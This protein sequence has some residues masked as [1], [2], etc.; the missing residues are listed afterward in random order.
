MKVYKDNTASHFQVNMRQPLELDNNWE[1]G[2]SELHFPCAWDNVRRG[3][4]K[5]LVRWRFQDKSMDKRLFL[6]PKVVPR[7]Y[8]ADTESL[9]AKVNELVKNTLLEFSKALYWNMIKFPDELS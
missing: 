3:S 8:Y 6:I 9:L 4:N 2:L 1:V 5:F 7:G